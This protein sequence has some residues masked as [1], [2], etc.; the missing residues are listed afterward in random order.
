MVR[1][2]RRT[3]TLALML[4]VLMSTLVACDPFPALPSGKADL[5]ITIDAVGGVSAALRLDAQQRSDAALMGLGLQLA[6]LLFPGSHEVSVAIDANGGGYPFVTITA[7]DAYEPGPHP[8]VPLDSSVAVR[9]LLDHGFHS[10]DV[11][12]TATPGA[13]SAAWTPPT[14]PIDPGQDVWVWE[15]V[16]SEAGAPGGVIR[17]EPE[18]WKGVGALA[19]ALLPLALLTLGAVALGRRQRARALVAG[20]STFGCLVAML[21]VP[22]VGMVDQLGVAGYLAGAPLTVAQWLPL[23][24]LVTGPTG[25]G[26][27]IAALA[28]RGSP[29]ALRPGPWPMPPH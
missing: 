1:G 13:V 11:Y 23:S 27:A 26:I 6:P 3:R 8:E 24:L 16:R 17:L 21:A 2:M 20:L 22:P 4:V 7:R 9:Y 10:V 5:D 29:T 28:M 18:P 12:V 15:D 25:L 14:E 19:L